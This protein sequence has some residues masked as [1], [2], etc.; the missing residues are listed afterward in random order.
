MGWIYKAIEAGLWPWRPGKITAY[1]EQNF[2]RYGPT[3]TFEV[4]L[5]RNLPF[6]AYPDLLRDDPDTAALKVADEAFHFYRNRPALPVD[7]HIVL[8]E[9]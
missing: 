6:V 5:L 7:D 4:E 1:T 3:L 2:I 9:D 8:G